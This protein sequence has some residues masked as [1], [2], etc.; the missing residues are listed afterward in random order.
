MKRLAFGIRN[1]LMLVGIL[2]LLIGLPVT[3]IWVGLTIG[4]N[5]PLEIVSI[6]QVG[7]TCAARIEIG[8]YKAEG[9][10]LWRVFPYHNDYTLISRLRTTDFVDRDSNTLLV[11]AEHCVPGEHKFHVTIQPVGST[12]S[13]PRPLTVEFEFDS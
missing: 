5:P 6:E 1:L 9:P 3:L 10:M 12:V 11:A 7:N 8:G 4:A 13:L 2:T